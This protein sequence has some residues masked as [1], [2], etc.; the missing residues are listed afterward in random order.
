[1]ST[2]RMVFRWLAAAAVVAPLM[3]VQRA[4]A[5]DLENE[6][7]TEYKVT[8]AEPG[9]AKAEVKLGAGEKKM[10]VCAVCS[11]SVEGAQAVSASG[12]DRVIIKGGKLTKV[13]Q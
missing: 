9:A 1:M 6:D 12:L 11:V 13:E 10:D 7:A 8:L 5:V 2:A 3:L 4:Q